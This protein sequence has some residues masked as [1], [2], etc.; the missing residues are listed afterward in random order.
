M[1]DKVIDL[2]A[3]R[4]RL[5]S[6]E[7]ES[8]DYDEEIAWAEEEMDAVEEEIEGY[9]DHINDLTNYILEL[10]T[11]LGAIT[12]ARDSESVPKEWV[13]VWTKFKAEREIPEED[14]DDE[15][16]YEIVFEPDLEFPTDDN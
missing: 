11:Y 16:Q 12:I 6:P 5:R 7:P 1:S 9:G 10:A 2:E 13:E 8:L 4:K 3:A 14:E 15:V